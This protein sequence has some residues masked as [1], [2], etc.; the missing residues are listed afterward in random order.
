MVTQPKN[1]ADLKRRLR[2]GARF[3]VLQHQKA[4]Y[5][6]GVREVSQE[7]KTYRFTKIADNPNH[8]LSVANGGKGLRLPFDKASHYVFGNTI[9]WYNKP[10]GTP[11]NSLIMEFALIT[12]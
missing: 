11:D 7:F 10:V 12:G 2:V 8:P 4:D 6:G 1:L 3:R 5:N 9:K